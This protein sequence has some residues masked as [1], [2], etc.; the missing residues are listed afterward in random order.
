MYRSKL[1]SQ[2]LRHEIVSDIVH[3]QDQ[4]Q[5]AFLRVLQDLREGKCSQET[6]SYISDV[7]SKPL[8]NSDRIPVV[9]ICFSR[10]EESLHNSYN[11]RLLEGKQITFCSVDCGQTTGLRC[12]AEAKL[13]TKKNA[14]MLCLY[15]INDS[16]HYGTQCKF[17]KKVDENK[18]IINKH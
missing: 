14:P 13:Y 12:I 7:L 3:R 5:M 6:A 15:N 16:I 11:L 8:D 1:F 2:L 10:L 4:N 18:V 9:N 17:V